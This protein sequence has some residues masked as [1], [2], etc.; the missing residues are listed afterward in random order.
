MNRRRFCNDPKPRNGG[1]CCAGDSLETIVCNSTCCPDM[2]P[3]MLL[4]S[5]Q[6]T[7]SHN[8]LAVDGAWSSWT[9]WTAC[10]TSCGGGESYRRRWCDN[11]APQNGGKN[12]SGNDTEVQECSSQCCPGTV[13]PFTI[14]NSLKLRRSK[15][16]VEFVGKLGIL[17]SYVWKW[18]S[19]ATSSLQ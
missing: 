10:S 8:Y 5:S 13:A 18:N 15:R 6:K 3:G 14:F 17:F 16:A 1:S 19:L 12:C 7:L 9:N 2:L 4:S 11:P